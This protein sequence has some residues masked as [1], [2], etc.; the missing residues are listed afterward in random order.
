MRTAYARQVLG[1]QREADR[2][3]VRVRRH[4]KRHAQSPRCSNRLEA[5]AATASASTAQNRK[6][7]NSAK[8]HE[9]DNP[10]STAC[11]K[12][13]TPTKAGNTRTFVRLP[14]AA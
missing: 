7:H 14:L 12:K 5:T 1:A 6:R 11:H 13:P 2:L 4:V 10:K 3:G 8:G 9:P